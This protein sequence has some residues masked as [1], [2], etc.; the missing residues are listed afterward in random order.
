MQFDIRHAPT[1]CTL[2][3]TMDA[4]EQIS[5]QPNSMIAMSTGFEVKAAVASQMSGS[6]SALRGLKSL[7]VGE[8]V[9]TAQYTAKRDGERITLAPDQ[10]GEIVAL[11]VD[12]THRWCLA[13]GAFLAMIGQV[14]IDIEYVGVRGFLSTS[15]L[16]VMRTSGGGTV[17][18][19]SHGALVRE[20]L[21]E[22]QRLVI[23]NRYIVAFSQGVTFQTVTLTG[24]LKHSFLSGE[25]LVNRFEGPGSVIYQTRGR[26]SSGLLRGLLQTIF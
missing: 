17:F 15:G 10:L 5:A 18:A 2:D 7:A 8:N 22:G 16:F 4:G 11:P 1:F 13:S 3:L 14:G 26:P 25:G 23:D 20:E 19:A 6:G 24:S 9:F 12:E 21:A